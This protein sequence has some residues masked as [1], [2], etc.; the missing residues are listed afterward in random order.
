MKKNNSYYR[1]LVF[2]IT[3]LVTESQIFPQQL[4]KLSNKYVHPKTSVADTNIVIP[5]AWTFGILYGGYTDQQQSIER[6]KEIIAQNYP[7]DA[8]WID[9]WFWSFKE[10]GRGPK[11]Y[12]DYIGDN[13]SFPDRKAM[14]SFFQTLNIKAGFWIWDCILQTGNESAFNE[15]NER[16]FFKDTYIEKGSWHNYST[17]TAMHETG[18][19]AI[20]TLCGNIDFENP[21]AAYFFKQ[22]VK[23]FFDEGADFLK[24]DRTSAIHVCKTMFEITQEYGLE[25][26]GRGFI[27]SHTGG[28]ESNEYKKYPA[29]WT[30]DTRSDWTIEKPTKKF[31]SWVPE[32]ALKE[33]IKMFIDPLKET[34]KIPF[35]TNDVGGFD[36][37][38]TT[39]VDEE[40]FIRW[41]QFSMFTPIVELFSQPENKTSNLPYKYSKRADTLFKKYSH[42]RMQL[43]PYIYS[44]AQ[45]IRLDANP[46]MHNIETGKLSYMFGKELLVYPVYEKFAT[47]WEVKLPEGKWFDFWNDEILNGNSV[48]RINCGLEN[49]PLF[50]KT[51]SIIPMRNYARS[52][53]RGNNDT[54]TLH[55]YSGANTTFELIEDDGTSN[56]YLKGIYSKTVFNY[57]EGV[58]HSNLVINPMQGYYTNLSETRAFRVVIHGKVNVDRIKVNNMLINFSKIGK[59][60]ESDLFLS[61]VYTEALIE[62][63]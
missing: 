14:W 27:L 23:H 28:M 62:I 20:G 49:I 40:L 32:V 12:I 38:M 4:N 59:T 35:L 11:H 51:G 33:N 2:T 54:L 39:N 26:K 25:T 6:V 18:K 29:K 16:K 7:I 24:L 57:S 61:N 44:Y 53:E 47:S 46:I 43:F 22:K 37:G 10:K 1:L 60:F 63:Q 52:I 30:D 21:H 31:N 19:D 36:N 56:D 13:E 9:S 5:P 45:K 8:Y 50:V 17:T 55:I 41:M 48:Y 3:M 58:S 34:S 15:F 42:L